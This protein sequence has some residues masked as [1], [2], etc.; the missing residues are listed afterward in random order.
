MIFNIFFL[1]AFF[2]FLTYI[3]SPF[4]IVWE[5]HVQRRIL[6]FLLQ[7]Q[8]TQED[9][10]G[11]QHGI[12]I[13]LRNENIDSL[14]GLESSRKGASNV[15]LARWNAMQKFLKH[16]CTASQNKWA[17]AVLK[18]RW[19][20]CSQHLSTLAWKWARYLSSAQEH[21]A[22]I[23]PTTSHTISHRVTQ[24][25]PELCSPTRSP[26][27][28]QPKI[29]VEQGIPGSALKANWELQFTQVQDLTYWLQRVEKWRH[30]WKPNSR[31]ATDLHLTPWRSYSSCSTDF[32]SDLKHLL[33][34]CS[35]FEPQLKGTK[36]ENW[37]L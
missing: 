27:D 24:R 36:L 5:G 33:L 31:L 17:Q 26:I 1:S 2:F 10:R 16:F 29:S 21:T 37:T 30:F 4:S 34:S 32:P 20:R 12:S 7:D 25:C 23:S 18:Q 19:L 15:C 3:P 35:T 6:V 13:F 28:R 8:T 22:G 11:L 14:S 9:D